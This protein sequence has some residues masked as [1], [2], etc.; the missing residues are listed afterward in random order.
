[1]SD[2][3]ENIYELT[4]LQQG[5]L[6]ETLSKP[7]TDAYIIQFILTLDAALLDVSAWQR[8]WQAVLD[9]HAV[10]RSAF[11]WQDLDKPVQVVLRDVALPWATHDWRGHAEATQWVTWQDAD[12]KQPFALDE[13]PLFR[14]TLMHVDAATYRFVWTVHHLINDGWSYPILL[15]EVLSLYPAAVTG[16]PLELPMPRPF[17]DYIDWLQQQDIAQ[18]EHF[19]REQLRGFTETTPL[20]ASKPTPTGQAD[21]QT[22]HLLLSAEQTQQL[23]SF[24]QQHRLT[25]NTLL[26]GAWAI[27]LARYG[28]GDDVVF[29]GIVSGRPATLPG[30]EAMVGMFTNTVPVRIKLAPTASVLAWLQTLQQQQLD[31]EQYAH[32]SL[33]DIQGWSDVP[34]GAPL[35][36][37][38][39]AYENYPLQAD[40]ES[41]GLI[42]AMNAIERVQGDRI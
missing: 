25:L 24:A 30:V 33:V 27:L 38:I 37:S 18:A 2:N 23:R 1:M 11:Y 3:L 26:Q 22:Q 10:L 20:G 7:D 6:I 9:R 39:F 8:A 42:K 34:R 36:E 21:Y 12:L 15:N 29:G 28:A 16:K 4:P 14:C 17:V 32:C 19:W 41:L 5:L 40:W 31:R 35:F 13:A